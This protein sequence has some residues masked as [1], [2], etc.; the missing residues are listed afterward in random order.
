MNAVNEYKVLEECQIWL[1]FEDDFEGIV[2]VRPVLNI[3]FGKALL[4]QDS[5]RKVAIESGGGL[6]WENGF[7]ICP[8]TLREFA[9]EKAHVV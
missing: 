8:N 5:F 7:D 2:N 4:N 6:A 1:R 3:G 9:K